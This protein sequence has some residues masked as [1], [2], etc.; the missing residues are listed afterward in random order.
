M[1]GSKPA[2]FISILTTITIYN[3]KLFRMEMNSHFQE[4]VNIRIDT[5]FKVMFSLGRYNP[6]FRSS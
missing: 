4:A 1:A 2:I 5:H 6:I 3:F